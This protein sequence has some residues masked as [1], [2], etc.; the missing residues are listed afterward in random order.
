MSVLQYRCY[1]EGINALIYVFT[2]T[3]LLLAYAYTMDDD[4]DKMTEPLIIALLHISIVKLRK[5]VSN[6]NLC[7]YLAYVLQK[8]LLCLNHIKM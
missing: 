1:L 8:Q 5:L 6:F 4:G 7:Q 2:I 3:Q